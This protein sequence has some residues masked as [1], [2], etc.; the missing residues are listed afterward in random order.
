M[1]EIVEPNFAARIDAVRQK[2]EQANPGFAEYLATVPEVP[3]TLNMDEI[4]A[5]TDLND[6]RSVARAYFL[7]A[8]NEF[9]Q[10]NA[11]H[12]SDK[13][14][15]L[16]VQLFEDAMI[17]DPKERIARHR[18][19]LVGDCLEVATG[20]T[21]RGGSAG[22]WYEIWGT[23]IDRLHEFER[24]LLRVSEPMRRSLVSHKQG[25]PI[26]GD[27]CRVVTAIRQPQPTPTDWSQPDPF[28][29]HGDQEDIVGGPKTQR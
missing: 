3:A 7:F 11:G 28:G 29:L 5:Q 17:G 27:I 14:I 12:V 6:R 13:I 2:V 8:Y 24:K 23:S 15:E 1:E 4:I 10:R 18:A 22:D 26:R 25:L 9:G 20:P 21:V 16:M 19:L